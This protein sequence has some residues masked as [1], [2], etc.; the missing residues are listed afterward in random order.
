MPSRQTIYIAAAEWRWVILV[1]CALVLLTFVPLLWV[2][3]M[4][5]PNWQFMG[6]LHNYQDGAT[7]LSK[8]ALGENGSWLVTFQHTPE[9]HAGAF[10]Q[11]LYV[12]LGQLARVMGMPSLVL[13]HVARVGA[14][15]LMYAALYQLAA[16]IW[17]RVRTRR[18]FFVL[19]AVGSGLGWLF[20]PLTQIATFPDF[21][22]LPEAFP[23]YSTFMN[24]HFPLT[25]ACL[26]LLAGMFIVAFRPGA[27][28]DPALDHAWPIAGFLSV[29]LAF[30]YPQALV[31]IGGALGLYMLIRWWQMRRIDLRGLRWLLAVILPAVPIAVYYMS[32]V[33]YNPAF[34]EWNAQNITPTPSP[35]IMAIGFGIPLI[36]ALPGIYRAARRFERDGNRIMLLWLLAI[37]VMIYL[38]TNI[39]RRFAVGMMIPIAYFATRAME[40]VWIARISRR[41]RGFVFVLFIPLLA[42]SQ[43]FMLFLPALPAVFGNPQLAQGVFLERDYRIVYEWFSRSP[44]PEELVVL[45]SPNASVWLPGW[46]DGARVVY[47]HPFETLDAEAKKLS[48]LDWYLAADGFDCRALLE[49]W[50]VDYILYGPQERQLGETVDPAAQTDVCVSELNRVVNLGSVTV[51]AP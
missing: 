39:Q 51:Y 1:A 10:I 46:S 40:D 5:T 16:S 21:P 50:E 35:I 49:R 24:V 43:L 29:A 27:D 4:G 26:A 34:A 17:T 8:M 2:A 7:Y 13:F 30:L 14:A 48:V 22:L 15:L 20:A 9:P 37:I 31:P 41:W 45:A 3:L 36:L 6:V 32:V 44:E 19:V 28:T 38:P 23:L 25:L 47:G 42:L 33:S 11:V 18:I 12:L